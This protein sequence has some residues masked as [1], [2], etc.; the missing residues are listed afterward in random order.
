MEKLIVTSFYKYVNLYN[1]E[2]FQKEHLDFC[3]KIGIKGK[4]L[5]GNEGING[6][7]SGNKEQ[8]KEY[9]K[10]LKSYK[11]FSDIKFKDTESNYHPF[12][13]TIVRI[14]KEIVTSNFNVDPTK[15][16]HHLSPKELKKMYDKKEDFVIIDARNNYESKIGKFKN[17]IT[18]NIDIFR[19]FKKV[20]PKISKYKN[21]K[22]VLYCTGGIRCEKASAL[23]I[24][25]GF[26]DVS[27]VDG[28]IIN[29]INQYPGTYFEGRCFTFDARLSVETGNKE[30]SIC[31]KCHKPCGEYT[32]C[33]NIKCDKLFICCDE[34]KQEWYNSCSKN[35]RN[36]VKIRDLS[37]IN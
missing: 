15:T 23:L 17:A 10:K 33:A 12:R 8:I 28:G 13:K 20:V 26:K 4:V 37:K 6:S 3:N 35:C 5:I 18:P 14:R 19:D 22:V 11:E 36:S 29:Y 2:I 25:K 34:C 16:G 21:K 27:Q 24:K 7:I 30:I 9:K 32:N 1:L 31:E